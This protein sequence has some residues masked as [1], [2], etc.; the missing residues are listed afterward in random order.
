MILVG[1]S[2]VL[3]EVKAEAPLHDEDPMNDQIIWQ[4]YIQQ[5]ESL[6][7]ENR[8]S[9]FCK[10]AGFMRVVEVGQYFVTKDTGDFRQFQSVACREYTLPRDDRASQPKG[11][12]Q[13]N[14]RIRP[15][16][17]VTTSFQ[18]F[19]YGI[20][21]RIESVN[22]DSSHSWVRISYGTV[23]YVI[24][25][26]ED[27]TENLADPQEEQI[28]QT[29][30]NVVAAARSKAKAKPQPRELTETTATI[31]I[32]QRRWIDIEPSKQDLD[33]YDLSKKVINILP[34]NQTM[35]REEDGAI[36]FCKIKFHLRNHHSQIQNWSDDRW[37]AC[38][39]ARGGSKRR[40]QYCSENLGT[41][42]YL[43]ALQGHSGSNLIDPTQQDNVLSGTGI[44]P[45]I[46]HVGCTFNLYSIIKNGLVPGGQNLSRRQTVFFLPVDPRD[47]SHKDPEYIDFSVPRLARYLHTAWKRHQD[48]VFWVDVNLAIKEGLTF[49]QTRSNAIILQGTLPAHCILKV[50][51]LK[52]GEKL[53][54]RQYLSPRPPPKIS[55]KHDNNWTKGYDQSG[56]T[57]EHQP[58]GKLVQQSFGEA[59]R[60]EFS[61]PTQSKPTEDRTGKPVTQEIV[62]KSQGELSSS[63]RTGKPVKDEDNRVM[64]DHDRTEKPVE[65]SSHKV[66]EVGS[67]ENR[68]TTSSN[69]N[70]FNLAID[71][72]NIDFNI[73][74]V[75]NAMVKRSHGINVHNLIQQIE[76]HPQREALQSDLQQHRAFNPF[77]EESKDAIMA[78]GNTELCEIVDVEPKSQ[79]R[80]CLTYWDA[81]IVCCTCGYLMEDDTTENKKYIS[82]VLDLFSIPNFYIRKGRPHGHRYGKKAGCEET[83]QINFKEGVE[84]KS[85]KTFTIDLS[86]TSSSGR[87]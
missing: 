16:L 14:M 20:E 28:P 87:R 56:S 30:T 29:S 1:Q 81:G 57:V 79:C 59:P 51:R 25:S 55:L 8:L 41:I 58:V 86:V 4:H 73:S 67:L 18:H 36:E 26:I 74:G 40:Y 46:H 37:K 82:S 78:A 38:L 15:L 53:Y 54:E 2:I 71:D 75:P 83:L 3:G 13:G 70:K 47:E 32:H 44:F 60:V 45:Y 10:E 24:D 39:A 65:E 72:E 66:Q 50:E 19:K 49:Y 21:I 6:S 48:A 7:P 9:K 42:L 64:S 77:S 27:N 52:T 22:Q 76:N 31:P 23:K 63:D 68:D 5:V 12:I 80:A 33:S 85:M 35:Q 34:H 11:W 69:A 61:K 43:R 17:E 62:G 84:R